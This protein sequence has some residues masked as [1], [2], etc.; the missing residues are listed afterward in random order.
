MLGVSLAALAQAGAA[1][2]Y[3]IYPLKHKSAAD[4]EKILVEMLA[5]VEPDAHVVADTRQRQ[6]LVRGSAK[7]QQVVRELLALV[8]RA[9]E[10]PAAKGPQKAD[11]TEKAVLKAYPCAAGQEDATAARLRSAHAARGDVRVAVDPQGGQLLVLAPPGV[12]DEIARQLSAARPADDKGPVAARES[13]GAEGAAG[14]LD[15][16]VPLQ[17]SPPER[18]ESALRE[19][20]GPRLVPASPQPPGLR[21]YRF[22]DGAGR[23]IELVF[24]RRRMGVEVTGAATPAG[25]FMRL[26]RYLDSVPQADGRIVQVLPVRVADPSK[27]QQAVEAYR[28]GGLESRPRPL[29]PRTRD[30]GAPPAHRGSPTE[31]DQSRRFPHAGIELASYLFQAAGAEAGGGAAAD[32]PGADAPGAPATAPPA[33]KAAGEMPAFPAKELDAER[34]RMRELGPDVEIET[35]PDLDVIILRGRDRDVQEL[36]KIIEEIER[37]SAETQPVIEIYPLKHVEGEALSTIVREVNED[38]IV[39]RQGRVSITPL[40][41]PNALLLVGWGEAVKAAKELIRKLDQPVAAHTQQQVFRLKY[42]SATTVRSTI[43]EFFQGRTG[44]GPKVRLTS[45]PRTNSLV[46]DAAPRDLEE[47]ALLIERLDVDAAASVLQTRIFRLQH[48]LAADVYSTLQNAIDAARG[49]GAGGQK[50]AALELLTVDPKGQR[51]LKSGILN[52][53]RITPDVRLNTLIVAAP[54]DSMELVEALIRQLDSPGAV[55]QIKVFRVENGDANALIQMLRMLVPSQVGVAGPQLAAE[56]GESTIIPLRFSSDSRTNSIIAVGSPGDLKIIEA[57]L[58]RLDATDVVPRKNEVY[59]LKNSPAN[60]VALAV[61]DFLRSERQV[62]MAAPGTLSPFQ[63]IESE[64]IVV[65]EPVSNSLIISATP[66]FFEEIKKLVEQLDAQPSQVM[67]QVLIAE[68]QLRNTD[69]FGIELGLQDSVLFHR[70][71]LDKIFT[72]TNTT[73]LG[74]PSGIITSTEQIIQAATNTP[75]F[76]FNN[77]EPGNSGSAKALQNSNDVGSQGLSHFTLGRTNNELGFGGLV[78]SASSESVSILVRALQESQR[79]EVLG[80][81]QIMTLDNQSAFIQIGKRVP[82]ITG[83]QVNQIGQANTIDLVNTG[84]ILG[85]TPR[86]SPEGMVVMEIDAEKSDVGPESEG[87]PVSISGTTVIRSPS[88]NTT[89]AQTTVSARDGETIV[90]GG[91]I[92]RGTT[93]VD[94]KVPYLADIPVVGNLFKYQSTQNKRT[95]LLII[96]TPHVVRTPEEADRIKRTESAR[97]HWCLEDVYQVH[98]EA[99]LG[100]NGGQV[101]YPDTNPRG[102]PA[103][104]TGSPTPATRKRRGEES[105]AAAPGLEAVP[106]TLPMPDGGK[107]GPSG[108]PK[109]P[110]P[111]PPEPSLREESAG[112][113]APKSQASVIPAGY[114]VDRYSASPAVYDAPAPRNPSRPLDDWS[115]TG[116]ADAPAR[117][118]PVLPPEN[119]GSGFPR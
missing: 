14:R 118:Q 104:E 10:L 6:L 108:A 11:K 109:S 47:V 90:L 17:G 105:D 63:Q 96:L 1:A 71:L 88:F 114:N 35:L 74:T 82:R 113:N 119:P 60:D 97:M 54:A 39:G 33:P 78:L 31:D 77:Q 95:E 75:G 67:I 112:L 19:L 5:T 70:S 18:V 94:R 28:T 42:A 53:V 99:G 21:R 56:E 23:S 115:A 66:R 101:I 52:D 59:R 57:L 48:T 76:Q 61:N 65:P 85:V 9:P 51:V 8:D 73:Q 83:T 20:F 93:K 36:R 116:L 34:D 12:H 7:A 64:V 80:R 103:G 69:E 13:E 102:L 41:K 30:E 44:L 37:L 98:G 38:L 16:F 15:R 27:I 29:L 92:T 49:G 40:V 26:I 58:V 62:Q 46:V 81:P 4:A 43:Q 3:Q 24:D 72:T 22:V 117:F 2:Q 32:A 68:V 89:M 79:L 111:V 106:P 50:S 100:Q 25:Q 55:A 87:I 110:A 84:L 107:Y 91:L 45:D 86:I